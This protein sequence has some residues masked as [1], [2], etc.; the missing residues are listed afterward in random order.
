M[1]EKNTHSVIDLI[2]TNAKYCFS[3]TFVG[4]SYTMTSLVKNFAI[5]Y[6]MVAGIP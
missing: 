5:W 2:P 1:F 6:N 4:Y 3:Y